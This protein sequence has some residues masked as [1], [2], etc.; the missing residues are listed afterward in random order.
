MDLTGP[1]RAQVADDLLR[2]TFPDDNLE[3]YL[4]EVGGLPVSTEAE[5]VD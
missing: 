4:R 3:A 1:W 2:R 5:S